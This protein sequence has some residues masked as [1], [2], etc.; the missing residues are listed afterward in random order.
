MLSLK[1]D[2]ETGVMVLVDNQSLDRETISEYRVTVE[3]RDDL[4]RGN[5]NV[6][7]VHITV[8]DVNGINRT[9]LQTLSL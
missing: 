7:E 9:Y 2:S 8:L 3:A 1:I 6:T 5:V 4:G